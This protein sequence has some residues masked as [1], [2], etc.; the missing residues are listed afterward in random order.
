MRKPE[1]VLKIQM[2]LMENEREEQILNENLKKQNG[3]EMMV[4]LPRPRNNFIMIIFLNKASIKS[5]K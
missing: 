1:S 2:Q 3:D 5:F 4:E